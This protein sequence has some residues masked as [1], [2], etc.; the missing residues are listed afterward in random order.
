MALQNVLNDSDN[1]DVSLK[2]LE[3]AVLKKGEDIHN[4][5][6]MA[7]KLLG[8]DSPLLAASRGSNTG[9]WSQRRGQLT[10]IVRAS[11]LVLTKHGSHTAIQPYSFYTVGIYP[12]SLDW[13]AQEQGT[14]SLGVWLGAVS[15]FIDGT[16]SLC[17]CKV[18]RTKPHW[19]SF[20]SALSSALGLSYLP[21]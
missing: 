19:A 1:G 6:R 17:L 11:M 2:S 4:E 7:K 10:P 13:E 20:L 15:G 14:G 9:H 3:P 21:K 12:F 5:V 18:E 16:F 8:V